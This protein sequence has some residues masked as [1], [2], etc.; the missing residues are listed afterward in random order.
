MFVLDPPGDL[1]E[2]VRALRLERSHVDA[3]TGAARAR[4]AEAR[5]VAEA[6]ELLKRTLR[7]VS[8]DIPVSK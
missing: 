6:E 2:R 1:L 3:L 5:R 8:A 7:T 4:I